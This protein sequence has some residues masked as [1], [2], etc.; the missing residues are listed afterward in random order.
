MNIKYSKKKQEVREDPV[1]DGL[2]KSKDFLKKN[3]NAVIGTL[4]AVILVIGIVIS[5]NYFRNA[6]MRSARDEFGKAMIAYN[7][8]NYVDAIDQF[9]LVAENYKGSVTGILSAYML[10]SIHYQQG[11]YDEAITWYEPVQSSTKAHFISA[12]ALEGI[13]A[14]YDAKGDTASALQYL[15]K[16]AEDER[17]AFR[18]SAIKWKIA[19][20]TK[21]TDVPRAT[22]LCRE[23]IADTLA[24]DYHM[25]AEFLMA[26]LVTDNGK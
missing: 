23:I 5:M 7:E 12:Q 22:S 25:N 14:C 9:R 15:E 16:A 24:Q 11:S 3:S 26:S 1:I 13:A 21:E 4:V 17:I 10:G 19:L 6:R 20:L 2:L 18:R 8:Q